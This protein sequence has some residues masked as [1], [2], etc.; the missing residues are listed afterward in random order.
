MKNLKWLCFANT[1]LNY[2]ETLFKCSKSYILSSSPKKKQRAKVPINNY[3][4][5]D[6]KD[7]ENWDFCP[8]KKKHV[9][10]R[11]L[12]E[13]YM[14]LNMLSVSYR[15][16]RLVNTL[17]KFFNCMLSIFSPISDFCKAF[18]PFFCSCCIYWER[19]E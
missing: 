12:K 13:T 5:K 11:S 15:D 3:F 1:T 8:L 14:V 17:F 9:Q 18:V 2:G 7:I 10:K 4:L 16:G 19:E 6:V